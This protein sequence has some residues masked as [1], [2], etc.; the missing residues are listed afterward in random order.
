MEGPQKS[1][2]GTIAEDNRFATS[3]SLRIIL[4]GKTGC[5]KSATGNSILCQ[6]VF[7]SR[8]AAQP[9][10]RTCQAETGTWNGRNI[11]VVDTPSIFEAKAQAQE[12]Y[13]DIG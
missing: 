5:G 12:T 4:V 13:K 2:Y 10:T 8:L 7:E 3:P 9:V 6:P 11:L 1:R